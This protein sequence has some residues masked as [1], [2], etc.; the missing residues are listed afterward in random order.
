[1]DEIEIM[2]SLLPL[3]GAAV[4]ATAGA[5]ASHAAGEKDRQAA[6]HHRQVA[7]D[8]STKYS[9]LEKKYNEYVDK[10][11]QQ[12]ND[13]TYQHALNEL[14]KDLLRLALRL[15]QSLLRLQQSLFLHIWDNDDNKTLESLVEFKKAVLA[16]N[17]VLLQLNEEEIPFPAKYFAHNLEHSN[18]A[19]TEIL[20]SLFRNKIEISD[21]GIESISTDQLAF[22]VSTKNLDLMNSVCEDT[23]EIKTDSNSAAGSLE[24]FVTYEDYLKWFKRATPA[25][26][27]FSESIFYRSLRYQGKVS[28]S[29]SLEK[30][31]SASTSLETFATYEDY[32]K[33]FKR[34]T[35]AKEPFSERVFYR[36][37]RYECKL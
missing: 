11:K 23:S 18:E 28:A 5:F 8:L 37:L 14:E 29:A 2:F 35:S 3:L 36:S 20:E 21:K 32:L 1:L 33:W 16:T 10:S 15:Q 17:K 12:I 27:P 13:L 6:K 7:N 25:K 34:A 26:E 9:S 4:G 19:C 22:D 31:V 24:K 30:M